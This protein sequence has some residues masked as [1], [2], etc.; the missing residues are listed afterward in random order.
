[1]IPLCVRTS[2]RSVF[3]QNFL[4]RPLIT[5][6]VPNSTFKL[7]FVNSSLLRTD[8]KVSRLEKKNARLL[9][10]SKDIDVKD[11]IVTVPNL[12]CVGRIAVCPYLSSIIISGD[13]KTS[14]LIYSI[15][16]FTD[17]VSRWYIN[18]TKRDLSGCEF[19]VLYLLG[20][21]N[22]CVAQCKGKLANYHQ[23]VQNWHVK[24][25]F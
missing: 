7:A 15:A 22:S 25:L 1:M 19:L 17:L 23:F 18:L 16:G 14:L 4:S 10:S 5:K 2:C 24:T 11:K 8:T 12:L 21:E 13:Y 3:N 6:Q 9:S 20:S